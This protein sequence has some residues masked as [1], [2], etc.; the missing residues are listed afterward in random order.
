LVASIAVQCRWYHATP[1]E[2]AGSSARSSVISLQTRT[3]PR[4]R[5]L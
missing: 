1:E 4:R 5:R 3:Q 2:C